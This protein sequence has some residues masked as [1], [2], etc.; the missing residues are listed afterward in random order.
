MIA[1]RIQ[2]GVIWFAFAAA[3]ILATAPMWRLW[4]F[5]SN[6][7]IDELLQ[8]AICGGPITR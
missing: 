8:L 2:N 4:V 3:L 7:T 1:S 6:P 5:G